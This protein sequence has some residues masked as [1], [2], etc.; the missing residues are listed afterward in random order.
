MPDSFEKHMCLRAK[1]W[2]TNKSSRS[3][4]YLQ[5][6]EIHRD[7]LQVAENVVNERLSLAGLLHNEMPS[8]LLR[9]LD[10]RV[11]SHILHTCARSF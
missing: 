8:A 5:R 4:T 7:A 1:G 10:E 11:A 9:D 2:L 3:G 6:R